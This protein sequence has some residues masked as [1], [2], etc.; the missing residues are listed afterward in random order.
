MRVRVR[1]RVQLPV[2]ESERAGATLNGREHAGIEQKE[3]FMHAL[4]PLSFSRFIPWAVCLN[5]Y[6]KMS[7]AFRSVPWAS[8]ET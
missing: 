7:L 4:A 1:V 8:N 6:G 3:C 5:T 2:C